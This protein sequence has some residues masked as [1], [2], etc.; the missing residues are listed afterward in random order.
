MHMRC[1][2]VICKSKR[3]S[4]RLCWMVVVDFHFVL[5][6]SRIIV[7]RLRIDK[8]K[9]VLV[10]SVALTLSTID[11][12]SLSFVFVTSL[13]I[14]LY[15]WLNSYGFALSMVRLLFFVMLLF[16]FCRLCLS[17][18]FLFHFVRY[19]MISKLK[20]FLIALLLQWAKLSHT[21]NT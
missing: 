5:F 14:Q 18:W 17:H 15:Q 20:W 16:F 12:L 10:L 9:C 3:P 6:L 2:I 19:I 21:Q 1:V 4:N 7:I 13:S 8:K 11:Y